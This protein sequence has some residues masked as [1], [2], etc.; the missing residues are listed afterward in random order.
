MGYV[1]NS[2]DVHGG[3]SGDDLGVEGRDHG[4]VKT[5]EGLLSEMNLLVASSL[6]I[7]DDFFS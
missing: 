1:T 6:L 5:I 7:F 4:G 3:L 2:A